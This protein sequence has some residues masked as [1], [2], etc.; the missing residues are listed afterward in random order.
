MRPANKTTCT[1][2][3]FQTFGMLRVKRITTDDARA[4]NGINV[5]STLEAAYVGEWVLEGM[6]LA[7]TPHT[8]KCIA[9]SGSKRDAF[10][11]HESKQQPAFKDEIAAALLVALNK[12]DYV[13]PNATQMRLACDGKFIYA[14]AICAFSAAEL[15]D[16]PELLRVDGEGANLDADEFN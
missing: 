7:F 15:E 2:F 14:H 12:S 5:G 13:V 6:R 11:L 16:E 4:L 8:E 10:W 3:E 9:G 1:K